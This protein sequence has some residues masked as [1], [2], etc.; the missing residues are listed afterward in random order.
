VGEIVSYREAVLMAAGVGKRLKPWTD[1]RPKSLIEVGGVSLMERHLKHLEAGGIERTTIV[2]GHFGNQIR[3]RC[4]T[5]HGRM[6]IRYVEN[7]EYRRGSILSMRAGLEG[8]TRGAIFMDADVLYHRD[9]LRRL[10]ATDRDFCFLLDETAEETGEEMM[11]G[12][13]AGRV[14][15]IAR[16]VGKDWDQVGEGVGFFAIGGPLVGRIREIQDDFRKRGVVDV[17]Y[18]DSLLVLMQEAHASF[19]PVGDLPWTEIDFAEDLAKAETV[20]AK[21]KALGVES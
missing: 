20:L 19:I 18:E 13:K 11:L 10:I 5:Q 2:I 6:A 9:V 14:L 12:V 17:E 21:L 1:T 16:R 7:P 8:L 3:E 4:G 15:K